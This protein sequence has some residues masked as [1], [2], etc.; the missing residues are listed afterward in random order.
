MPPRPCSW[1]GSLVPKGERCP[2]RKD[3]RKRGTM[4]ERGYDAA[5]QKLRKA[6]L[7]RDNYQCRIGRPGCLGKANSCDHI[8]PK[9]HGGKDVLSN[10]QAACVPCNSGKR[11][12][13]V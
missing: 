10:L 5:F 8:V 1:C 4:K 9:E 13:R 7:I 12:R 2:C 11:D 3:K 6:V